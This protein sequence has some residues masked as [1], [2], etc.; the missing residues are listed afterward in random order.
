MPADASIVGRAT[1]TVFLLVPR[2][3]AARQWIKENIEGAITFGHGIAIEHRY[4]NNVAA[5]MKADGLT[6]EWRHTT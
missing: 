2:T 4:V 5:G 3:R 1:D 6:I